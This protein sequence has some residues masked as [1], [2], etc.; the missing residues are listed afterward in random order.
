MKTSHPMSVLSS[1]PQSSSR[2]GSTEAV[3]AVLDA[4]ARPPWVTVCRNETQTTRGPAV[5]QAG[6]LGKSSPSGQRREGRSAGLICLAEWMGLKSRLKHGWRSPGRPADAPQRREQQ[7]CAPAMGEPT[8]A[9][10]QASRKRP[11]L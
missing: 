8:T 2:R 10:G 5:G 3:E 7:A 1:V 9:S 6:R 11:R 4:V